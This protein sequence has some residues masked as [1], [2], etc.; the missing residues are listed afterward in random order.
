MKGSILLTAVWS[1]VVIA[2]GYDSYFAWREQ[3]AIEA[4]EMNPVARW[5]ARALGV[6]TLI[7]FKAAG[8]AFGIG[9]AVFCHRRHHRLA[10]GF[11]TIVGSAY[12]LLSAYYIVCHVGGASESLSLSPE[13]ARASTVTP[14]QQYPSVLICLRRSAIQRS[15]TP[16]SRWPGDWRLPARTSAFGR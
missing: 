7:G 1:F 16:Q 10:R 14:A 4:W 15:K 11:T 5:A 13:S 9:L 3:A 8:I 12:L 2:A 6:Q